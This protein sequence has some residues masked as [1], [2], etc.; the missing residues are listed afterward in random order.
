M[1]TY[2]FIMSFA[3]TFQSIHKLKEAIQEFHS[4]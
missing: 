2:T 4:Y 3:V 1:N